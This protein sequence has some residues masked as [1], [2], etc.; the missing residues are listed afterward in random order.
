MRIVLPLA[1]LAIACASIPPPRSPPPVTASAE[2]KPE[3]PRSSI[4]AILVHRED[5]GLTP[6]QVETLV[7]RDD[8]LAREDAPLRSSLASTSSG[9][10]VLTEARRPRVSEIARASREAVHDP[11]HP[12]TVHGRADAGSPPR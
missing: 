10:Q 3:L 11:Q 5:L 4:A 8:A 2:Q 6:M 9:G 12:S 1:A 7:R